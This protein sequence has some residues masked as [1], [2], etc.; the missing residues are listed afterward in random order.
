MGT[1]SR[2]SSSFCVHALSPGRLHDHFEYF[3]AD[4]TRSRATPPLSRTNV[5]T[6]IQLALVPNSMSR[7]R[8]AREERK[9]CEVERTARSRV[10]PRSVGRVRPCVHVEL[11]QRELLHTQG[12]EIVAELLLRVRRPRVGASD[13]CR[14]PLARYSLGWRNWYDFGVSSRLSWRILLPPRGQQRRVPA[15]PSR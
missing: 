11:V 1:R 2:I 15:R 13:R 9:C 7:G 3:R 10:T 4:R 12:T 14:F 5:T 6:V 8:E